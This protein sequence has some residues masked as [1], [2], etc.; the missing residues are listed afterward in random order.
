M[1]T[2]KTILFNLALEKYE[3]IYNKHIS[4]LEQ[5]HRECLME[6]QKRRNILDGKYLFFEKFKEAMIDEYYDVRVEQDDEK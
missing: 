5:K 2:Q 3:E 1:V 4:Q 6:E